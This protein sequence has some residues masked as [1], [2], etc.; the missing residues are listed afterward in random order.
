MNNKEHSPKNILF[1]EVIW[2][3]YKC[4]ITEMTQIVYPREHL[5]WFSG[6]VQFGILLS[7]AIC[8]WYIDLTGLIIRLRIL[9]EVF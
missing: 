3:S 5:F 9:N 8:G 1:Y 7:K 4:V 2:F 6:G